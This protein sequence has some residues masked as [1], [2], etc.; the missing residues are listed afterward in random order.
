MNTAL[1]NK[2]IFAFSTEDKR[3]LRN[4][5]YTRRLSDEKVNCLQ[6]SSFVNKNVNNTNNV[7][8][9]S[10]YGYSNSA[11]KGVGDIAFERLLEQNY[12]KNYIKKHEMVSI[13][14]KLKER[15]VLISKINGTKY[16]DEERKFQELEKLLREHKPKLVR[17]GDASQDEDL[18]KLFYRQLDD[19]LED[20]KCSKA[21]EKETFYD[22][23]CSWAKIVYGRYSN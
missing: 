18:I 10:E 16:E 6:N 5:S 19:F 15:L 22:L 13:D 8:R 7:N 20:F 12:A 14:D 21:E 1:Q 23:I 11:N 17:Y 2:Y 9:P 3:L 4:T